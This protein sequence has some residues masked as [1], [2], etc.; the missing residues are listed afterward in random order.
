MPEDKKPAQPFELPADLTTLTPEDLKSL[1]DKAR[2]EFAEIA[3]TRNPE[4]LERATALSEA[5]KAIT[6]ETTRRAEESAAINAQFDQMVAGMEAEKPAEPEK[7][8]EVAPAAEATPPAAPP[9]APATAAP[10]LATVASSSTVAIPR[11]LGGLSQA[12]RINPSMSQARGIAPQQAAPTEQFQIFAAAELPNS[13]LVAGSRIDSLAT[14][15]TLMEHRARNSPV[16][17]S[18]WRPG[19]PYGGNAVARVQ[20]SFADVFSETSGI[21]AVELYRQKIAQGSRP[22]TMESLVAA[23][24]WCA[25]SQ[26]KYDFFNIACAGGAIDL[27]T[28]GV[29]RGG[30]KYPVSPTLANA[31]SFDPDIATGVPTVLTVPWLWTETTDAIAATGGAG[32]VVKPCIRVPCASFEE[33]RLECIGVCVTAGNLADN[34][35]PEATANFLRMLD[36]AFAH[37]KNAQDITTIRS[38]TTDMGT[39]SCTGVGAASP[40][41]D[42]AEL[43]AVDYRKKLLMCWND[44]IE[45]V[46]PEWIVPVLRADVARRTGV[47]LIGVTDEM[48]LQWFSARHL[49]LQLVDDYQVRSTGQP[50]VSAGITA[51]PTTVEFMLWA[52]GTFARGNGMTLDLGVVRDSTLNDTNDHTAAWYEE[53]RLIAMFGHL[54]RRYTVNVCASGV[55]GSAN[56]TTCCN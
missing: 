46:F 3:K 35:W 32:L 17:R 21:A 8:A 22:D 37:A 26:I 12:P 38:L 25:P 40:V 6:A 29:Q 18:G 34:A 27:P 36:V 15:G 51:W 47:D 14:L 49:R 42:I 5:V 20:N 39:V 43:A 16:T 7:P 54:A 56:I 48:V 53:C 41:L 31:T 9:A 23:G 30:I 55:T 28:F 11:E 10:A 4:D 50:G 19:D 13:S 1:N 52:P 24:G 44:V 45:V 2:A 33:K